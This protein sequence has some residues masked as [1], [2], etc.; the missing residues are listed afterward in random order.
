MKTMHSLPWNL[1]SYKGSGGIYVEFFAPTSSTWPSLATAPITLSGVAMFC[2]KNSRS[3]FGEICHFIDHYINLSGHCGNCWGKGMLNL[4]HSDRSFLVHSPRFA[5]SGSN[6]PHH[7]KVNLLHFSIAVQDSA[8]FHLLQ[9]DAQVRLST[10]TRGHS[11]RFRP[12]GS[13]NVAGSHGMF[14]MSDHAE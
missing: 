5:M 4:S 7:S 1:H 12:K 6:C 10:A 11:C 8:V 13:L 14:V 2:S 3:T 9:H